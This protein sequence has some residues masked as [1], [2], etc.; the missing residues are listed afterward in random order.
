MTYMLFIIFV[1]TDDYGLCICFV[2]II[3]PDFFCFDGKIGYQRILYCSCTFVKWFSPNR[4]D[5]FLFSRIFF[6]LAAK[7][8]FYV[9]T[10]TLP[11]MAG[12]ISTF[13]DFFHFDGQIVF[14]H[15]KMVLFTLSLF[16]QYGM[17]YF[18]VPG[19]YSFWRPNLLRTFLNALVHSVIIFPVW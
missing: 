4:A 3:I 6:I 19:F 14:G 17:T 8:F 9:A 13:P 18:Y 12:H 5:I 1:F 15:F 11:D 10:L 2:L 16:Y 7:F